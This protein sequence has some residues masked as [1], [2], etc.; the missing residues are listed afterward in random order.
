MATSSSALIYPRGNRFNLA[1]VALCLL[2]CGCESPAAL[3]DAA[4]VLI[5]DRSRL[6]RKID[7]KINL[8]VNAA[9]LNQGN[10]LFHDVTVDVYEG[11][12]LLT[13][14]VK[15][16]EDKRMA[17][18][19][20]TNIENVLKV[21]NEIRI[22]EGNGIREA[23]ADITIETK[24]KSALRSADGVHS[25]NMRWR[26][27]GGTVYLFGRALSKEEQELAIVTIKDI[28]GVEQLINVQKIVR[29]EK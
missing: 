25:V 3:F 22:A 16:P 23:A 12:V 8:E 13:G 4:L 6:N 27:V 1:F 2:I 19:L 26:S 17:G 14:S 10:G 29:L 24:I 9:F 20:V 15:K 5:E 11:D 28:R 7:T 21:L 18:A